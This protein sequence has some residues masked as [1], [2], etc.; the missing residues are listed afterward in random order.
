MWDCN[1]VNTT[2]LNYSVKG[3]FVSLFGWDLLLRIIFHMQQVSLGNWNILC[4]FFKFR[5]RTIAPVIVISD[6]AVMSR[7]HG[8]CIAP[9]S[10][11]MGVSANFISP[12]PIY[13]KTY[14]ITDISVSDAS[15]IIILYCTCKVIKIFLKTT[16]KNQWSIPEHTTSSVSYSL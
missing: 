9:Y 1:S 15:L 7:S 3:D 14:D 10:K 13:R 11:S 2:L 5:Y 12:I 4:I 8:F 16:S 6:S